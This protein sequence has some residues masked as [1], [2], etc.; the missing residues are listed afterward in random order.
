MLFICRCF[1]LFSGISTFL[2]RQENP[3]NAMQ[4][5]IYMWHKKWHISFPI[6][7]ECRLFYSLLFLVFFF[8][9]LSFI[10]VCLLFRGFL[11]IFFSFLL[12]LFVLGGCLLWFC[13]IFGRV[14]P[15]KRSAKLLWKKVGKEKDGNKFID[16]PRG[17]NDNHA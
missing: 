12:V 11:F 3:L 4:T 13:F 16:V 5:D 14:F 15:W 6:V 7:V 17:V 8:S 9:F 2:A 1:S 10:L